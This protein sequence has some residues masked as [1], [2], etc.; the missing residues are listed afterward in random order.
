MLHPW[1]AAMKPN[2]W[3]Y[4]RYSHHMIRNL[5]S[6]DDGSS[7]SMTSWALHL[8]LTWSLHFCARCLSH[9]SG[10]RPVPRI[11]DLVEKLECQLKSKYE[12]GY[13][14]QLHSS[15]KSL[16]EAKQT[17]HVTLDA[18]TLQETLTS[19]QADCES[20]SQ[21]VYAT[22]VSQMLLSGGILKRILMLTSRLLQHWRARLQPHTSMC[23]SFCLSSAW[24]MILLP[25][26][27]PQKSH[28]SPWMPIN[29]WCS[30]FSWAA[31]SATDPPADMLQKMW[32]LSVH[33]RPTTCYQG[34]KSQRQSRCISMHRVRA[35]P[36]HLWIGSHCTVCLQPLFLLRSLM[37]SEYSWT[38]LP[39]SFISDSTS[40]IN[41]YATFWGWL[42]LK[43][44]RVWLWQTTALKAH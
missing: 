32:S 19:Y 1:R 30:G 28:P 13:V 16:Q 39:G 29:D 41:S 20:Y 15:I 4:S 11:L 5:L 42:T 31:V 27:K 35:W 2:L 17:N 37:I 43:H 26:P 6:E 44:P 40:S 21:H 38:S 8:I 14:E 34:S 23:L 33:M 10:Q 9:S 24:H 22:I 25:Q 3:R 36:T 7:A 18:S 12:K